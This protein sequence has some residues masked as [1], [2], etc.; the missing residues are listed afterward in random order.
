MKH[1][2]LSILILFPL[3]GCAQNSK[4][5]EKEVNEIFSDLGEYVKHRDQAVNYHANIYIGAVNFEVLIND[6]PVQKFY[7]PATGAI[8]TSIPINTAILKPGKQTWKIK[9]YPSLTHKVDENGEI[10]ASMPDTAISKGGRIEMNIEG[11]YYDENGNIV[12]E[13]HNIVSFEAPLRED[14]ETGRMILVDAGKPYVEYSGTFEAKVP[15]QLEG[16]SEGQDL[17]QLD[18]DDLEEKVVKVYKEFSKNWGD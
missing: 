11:I 17:T 15:Y 3:L 14:P 6:F 1:F 4:N 16:W 18:T 12:K 13:D 5:M 9:V 8:S 10:I 2:V 7:R